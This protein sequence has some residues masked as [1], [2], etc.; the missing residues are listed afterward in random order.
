MPGWGAARVDPPHTSCGVAGARRQQQAARA[1]RALGAA[2]PS[3][4]LLPQFPPA[5]LTPSPPKGSLWP[6]QGLLRDMGIQPLRYPR[7]AGTRSPRCPQRGEQPGCTAAWQGMAAVEGPGGQTTPDPG[8]AG[9]WRQ[10]S[11]AQLPAGPSAVPSALGVPADPLGPPGC[12]QAGSRAGRRQGKGRGGAAWP[13]PERRG[14]QEAGREGGGQR[15]LGDP[16]ITCSANGFLGFVEDV[17]TWV[18]GG[19]DVLA[20]PRQQRVV[21][22]P[23]IVGVEE[24][25]KPLDEL[26]VVLE[27]ALH[28]PLHRDDLGGAQRGWGAALPA[29]PPP[30]FT[31]PPPMD[32]LCPLPSS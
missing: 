13:Q 28:Q 20:L 30:L 3:A 27:L 7:G 11:P 18:W 17:I 14:V 12:R 1:G 22:L 23:V 26:E 31:T 29:R 19:R 25:L 2:L 9:R 32:L 15:S 16:D 24:L 4:S 10:P 6:G 8:A 21:L 5:D